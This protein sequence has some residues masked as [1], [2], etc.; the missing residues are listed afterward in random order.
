[1]KDRIVSMVC[2]FACV[3]ALA[4]G[5]NANR[6]ADALEQELTKTDNAL[7]KV[8]YVA[9]HTLD[10]VEEIE[11]EQLELAQAMLAVARSEHSNAAALE[12]LCADGSTKAVDAGNPL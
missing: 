1:M 10:E 5:W 9:G 7:G 2:G 6:R 4:A 11:V 12:H 3:V 8:S